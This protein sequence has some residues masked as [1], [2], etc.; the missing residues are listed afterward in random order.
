MPE[1][2]IACASLP[3]A[4]ITSVPIVD[5]A[6]ANEG[7]ANM[8]METYFECCG[9]SICG[10][11]IHSFRM[12]GND[13]KCPFCKADLRGK[14]DL[15]RVEELMK[16]VEA[17]DAGSMM[18]LGSHYY[19]GKLGLLQDREKAIELWTQAADLGSSQ[20]HYQLGC[21]Y[22]EGGDSKKG[23]FHFEAAAMAGH[24]IA[25][26]NLGYME[27]Q[28]GNMG[29]AVKHWM[30]AA[31]AGHYGAMKNLLIAFNQGVSSRA[32]IDSTLEAY[33][34]SCAEVRSEARDKY[35]SAGLTHVVN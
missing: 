21:T 4:T 30:I 3:P 23:K 9:K 8:S 11:C 10:G 14:T 19:H 2:L 25:R 12:S 13:E 26:H 15:N 28:S 29:Q 20:A 17:N 6:K 24:E 33:N 34:N 27:A 5:F 1:H 35:I 22:D 18:V 16:R 7:L 31:S 32:Q